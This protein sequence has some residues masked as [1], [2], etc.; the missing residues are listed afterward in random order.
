LILKN[1]WAL[2]LLV[3]IAAVLAAVLVSW[4]T[5]HPII[6]PAPPSELRESV[7]DPPLLEGNRSDLWPETR[8]AFVAKN[9][10]CAACG[11]R[12]DLNVHHLIP[13]YLRPDLELVESN[14]ITLC[15]EHHFR[16]GH[17]PDGPW[18]P[19]RPSWR[20]YNPRVIEHAGQ[21]LAG[22]PILR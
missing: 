13:F 5:S 1:S 22:R 20:A 10:A 15:R 12:I 14:L 4:A 8:A 7:D 2:D 11:K 17:D 21:V 9:P 18:E 6:P 19:E 3:A 16:V